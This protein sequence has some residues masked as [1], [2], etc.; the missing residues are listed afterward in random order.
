MQ[1]L[2]RRVA[3]WGA[4][5]VVLLVGCVEQRMTRRVE[6]Y[7]ALHQ[8]SPYVESALRHHQVVPGM[9]LDEV[10]AAIGTPLSLSRKG[11]RYGFAFAEAYR[12]RQYGHAD[13]VWVFFD[14]DSTVVLVEQ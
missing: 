11:P 10:R 13:T 9:T 8:P 5:S 14:R 12:V 1:D 4:M 6:Q 7:I 2:G 3:L